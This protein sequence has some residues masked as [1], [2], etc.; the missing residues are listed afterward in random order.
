MSEET[1]KSTKYVDL[2]ALGKEAIDAIKRP[3]HAR[4]AR[5]QLE[6]EIIDLEQKI[7]EYDIKIMDAKTAFPFKLDSIL[8]AIDEKELTERKLGQAEE[9]LS[10]LF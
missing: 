4:K 5:K 9:L 8:D 10:E 1:L 3:F 2:L 7:A 6:S